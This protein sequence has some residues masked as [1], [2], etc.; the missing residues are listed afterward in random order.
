MWRKYHTHHAGGR[1]NLYVLHRFV[2]AS[3]DMAG[4][5]DVLPV[6][7]RL[8]A[9]AAEPYLWQSAL[10]AVIDLVAAGHGFI[11]AGD[12]V[13]KRGVI[14]NA[15]VDEGVLAAVSAPEPARLVL[16]LVLAIPQGLTTRD[17]VIS[18]HDFEASA[19]YNEFCRPLNGFHSLHLRRNG[20][21]DAFLLSLCRPR[22]S[23]RFDADDT[24]VLAR[25]APHVAGALA[26]YRRL[27]T[28]E[29]REAGLARVLDRLDAGTILA[30]ACGRPV[31]LN[32]RAERIIGEADG[33]SLDAG[34][35]VTA[36]ATAT[37]DLRAAIAAAAGDAAAEPQRVRLQRPSRRL[38]LMLTVLPI[39]RLGPVLPGIAAP[40]VAIFISEPDQPPTIDVVALAEI[41]GLTGREGEVATLLADGLD[42]ETIA[43]RFGI[44]LGT[45]RGYLKGVFDKTGA[46]SQSSL[47]ALLRG[48]ADRIR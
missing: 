31:M 36:T 45:V 27:S 21:S 35:L 29:Q 44:G 7:E 24:A 33:L 17:E 3:G 22:S 37:Q 2:R 39:W 15:R 16:P 25:L 46:R 20:A 23:G 26:L 32:A 18:D 4:G 40:R 28:A 41:F 42:L 5:D 30:D 8:Y 38:P 10:E 6:I 14:V 19:M 9:A 48:F 12:E 11:D 13:G 34:G 1:D 43:S 47:V